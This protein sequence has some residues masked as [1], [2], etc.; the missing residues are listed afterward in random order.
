MKCFIYKS[1]CESEMYLYIAK[2][3]DFGAVP[4]ELLDRFGI[5]DFVMELELTPERSL[6]RENPETVRAN[7]KE[8]GFHLQMPP[9]D[10]TL[11]T[12]KI[13]ERLTLH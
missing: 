9:K 7:L 11:Q 1:R 13:L 6:A 2:R 12:E 3:D 8:R 4:N 5:P 10:P